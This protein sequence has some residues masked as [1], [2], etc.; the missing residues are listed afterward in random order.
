MLE[1]SL[2]CPPSASDFKSEVDVYVQLQQ[3]VETHQHIKRWIFKMDGE[4]EGRGIAYIGKCA[5]LLFYSLC[6]NSR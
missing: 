4:V 6:R 1:H 2:P 5:S 3:L